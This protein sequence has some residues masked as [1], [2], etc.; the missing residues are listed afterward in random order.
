MTVSP[1]TMSDVEAAA[2]RLAG[3]VFRTPVLESAALNRSLGA[4]VLLKPECLQRSGSFKFR[5][6]FNRLARLDDSQR[7]AG[8][9]AFSSGNHAQGVAAAAQLLGVPATIVMPHDAPRIKRDNTLAYGA[10]VIGFDRQTEIREEIAAALAAEQ[11]A[12]LVPSY[13][14]VDIIAGQGTCGLELAA[15]AA[16]LGVVLDVLLVCCGGGGLSAGIATAFAAASSATAIYSVEPEAFDDTARSLAADVRQANPPHAR[17]ICDALLASTPGEITFEINRR[18]LAGGLAVS[19]AEVCMAMRYAFSTLKL[20][21]EPGG[22]VALAAALT[23]K[24]PLAG[25]NVGVIISGGNVDA[26]LYAAI[27]EGRESVG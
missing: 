16:E 17:S 2:Q 10:E 23:E 1:V 5:G 13:D 15:Q 6:A 18:R 14:D 20:V 26:E 12:V 27:I 8:V 22:A 19:D 24:L 21:V 4:R 3:Q 7:A 11:G 25:R 9:V